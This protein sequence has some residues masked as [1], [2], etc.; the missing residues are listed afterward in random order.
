MNLFLLCCRS[1]QCHVLSEDLKGKYQKYKQSPRRPK[2]RIYRAPPPL[3]VGYSDSSTET[4]SE[5][6]LQQPRDQHDFLSKIGEKAKGSQEKV[7]V[8]KS[9]SSPGIY[10]QTRQPVL[11]DITPKNEIPRVTSDIHDIE[12]KQQSQE[13]EDE[14]DLFKFPLLESK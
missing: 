2:R 3:I 14:E 1:G 13:E 8:Q 7:H 9:P 11:P 4:E 10:M 12:S 5:L 6:D